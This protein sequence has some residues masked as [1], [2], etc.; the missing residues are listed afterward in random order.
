MQDPV[1]LTNCDREPIHIPGSIQPHGAMLVCDPATFEILFASENLQAVTGC[2]HADLTGLDLAAIVGDEAAHDIR[3]ASAKTGGSEIAGVVLAA[4]LPRSSQAMDVIVHRYKDRAFVEI[5]PSDTANSGHEALDTTQIL[6]RRIGLESD[7][8]A[9]ASTGAKLVRGMLGYDRV[10]IYQFLHNGAGKVIAEAKRSSLGS[11]MGQHFPAADIPYQARRLYLANTIRMI[12]DVGYAPVPLQPPLEPGQ[13]PVDMSFAQL[14][15]VSPIHCQYLRNMGVYAS[16]SISIVVDGEL[17]GL[18]SCHHDSPK[19]TPL[20]LR[21][22]AELFGQYFSL[23]ISLAERRAQIGAA[24]LARDR[25]DKIITHLSATDSLAEN[26]RGHLDDLADLV[27]CDGVALWMDGVWTAQ[28]RTPPAD[29]VQGLIDVIKTGAAGAVWHTQDLRQATGTALYGQAY[30]G[31]LAV[32]LS[33]TPQDYL[34]FFRSEEAHAIEWAGEPVKTLVQS[35]QGERLTPRGSFATWREEVRDRSKPWT[36]AEHAVAEAIRTYLRDVL[37]RHSERTADERQRIEQRRRIL[38]DEL[39]HRVKN[40]IALVKSIALQTGAHAASVADYSASLEGRLRALAFAH[41]QS[42]AGQSNGD[43]ATLI[44]AEAS[45]YRYGAAPDRV[46][47]SGPK[48]RLDD[49]AFSTL[50][51]VI[52]E[53]M[54]NAAK[55][56]AL[57]TPEG[58]LDI[59]WAFDAAGDC[60]IR[61]YESGGPRVNTPERSGFG[62]KLVQST[63][64]YDLKGQA[65]VSYDPSGVQARF[66]IPATHAVL[67]DRDLPVTEPDDQTTGSLDNLNILVVEDQALIAM[68]IEET[69]KSLGVREVR[70]SST[71]SDA[72]ELLAGFRPDAAVLDFNLGAETSEAVAKDLLARGIPFVFA[73]GY[74]DTVM[75]PAQFA[76]T[77]IV[78]KPVS[79]TSL[80]AKIQQARFSADGEPAVSPTS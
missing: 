17:W 33:S 27:D 67:D 29:A 39:N 70:A 46:T 65:R 47:A 50:A 71:T 28:G 42:L 51:L 5:E 13:S 2:A 15:S 43:L 1:N 25:L 38:N 63:L 57:S 9:I 73:T 37:L 34:L 20:P 22:G 66:V 10:M 16:L 11:F 41:D 80:V 21:I 53:M 49:Q 54:T 12:G 58:R 8:A 75:I 52:H 68:D 7:V 61:W 44:E 30:A 77:P 3:N 60:E 32:P 56:G 64:T 45:L 62:T 40:I 18:I 14:R 36:S 6:I 55:Y 31:L 78:R 26:L 24:N 74:G 79:A 4:R 35:D 19:V 23:Q 48:A 72:L 76:K 69:L 59:R